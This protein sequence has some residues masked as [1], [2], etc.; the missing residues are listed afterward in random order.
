[1]ASPSPNQAFWNL[2]LFWPNWAKPTAI[3]ASAEKTR[4][5]PFANNATF[6]HTMISSP[7]LEQFSSIE[8]EQSL[9]HSN[10][11]VS[12]D[13]WWVRAHRVY[14]FYGAWLLLRL[15]IDSNQSRYMPT[16]I[17]WQAWSTRQCSELILTTSPGESYYWSC[18]QSKSVLTPGSLRRFAEFPSAILTG[19]N[20]A[21]TRAKLIACTW[22]I[23]RTSIWEDFVRYSLSPARRHGVTWNCQ[24]KKSRKEKDL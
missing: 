7:A 21:K 8:V 14:Y 17:R 19:L 22:R 1:M 23:C 3:L 12:I 11:A 15:F 18:G 5:K 6:W 4:N 13:S 16:W 9:P 2:G 20:S 10:P 24:K